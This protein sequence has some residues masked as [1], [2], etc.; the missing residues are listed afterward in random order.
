MKSCCEEVNFAVLQSNQRRVLLIVLSINL[1]M[2]FVEMVGGIVSRSTSL[3]ADSLDMLG[4]S[5]VYGLGLFAIGRGIRW[6]A[7]AALVKGCIMLAFGIGVLMEAIIKSFFAN[8]TTGSYDGH[9]WPSCV[10]R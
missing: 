5:L 3:L 4:D 8:P 7:G 2:F 1:A 6:Q 9:H 10:Y